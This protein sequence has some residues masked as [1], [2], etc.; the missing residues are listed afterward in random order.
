MLCGARPQRAVS[1]LLRTPPPA[2]PGSHQPPTPCPTSP[3]P[4]AAPLWGPPAAATA[5]SY[6][7]ATSCPI[8]PGRA[9]PAS[10]LVSTTTVKPIIHVAADV[11]GETLPGATMFDDPVAVLFADGRSEE[12]RV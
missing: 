6:N 10:R 8:L 2:T 4:P 11:R 1:A 9:W 12:R 7:P 3:R 5:G